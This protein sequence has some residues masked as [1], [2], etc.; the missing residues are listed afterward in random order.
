MSEKKIIIKLQ[1]GANSS[2]TTTTPSNKAPLEYD[3]NYSRIFGLLIVLALI[4]GSLFFV[5][6]DQPFNEVVDSPGS[7]DSEKTQT[8]TSQSE[9][10]VTHYPEKR[11]KSDGFTAVRELD[12]AIRKK[13]ILVDV[14]EESASQ[15]D[16]AGSDSQ[17]SVDESDRVAI[18]K[19]QKQSQVDQRTS[20]DSMIPDNLLS[21]AISRA[22]FSWG[23]KDKEPT[24]SVIS[25][26]ILQR[27]DS[28]T[29]YFFS[30]FN[31][32]KG[33]ELIHEWN[34]NGKSVARRKFRI[35][36]K[37]WRVFS[38]K[39]LNNRSFGDWKVV[40]KN[41]DGTTLGE[42]LLQIIEPARR[43]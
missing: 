15:V 41:I 29:L 1:Y 24:G 9:K 35:H 5:T 21:D 13:P 27:G 22:Q 6:S 31:N 33:K 4:A 37:R 34:F 16:D 32:L 40:V 7:L 36:G 43:R 12:S 23:I 39:L 25:P 14:Q 17:S 19:Q 28:V 42:Y 2:G 18:E 3:W 26:A 38:S 20:T 30:E 10:V 11:A 8:V